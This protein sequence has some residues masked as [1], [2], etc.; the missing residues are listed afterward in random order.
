MPS[1]G[2]PRIHASFDPLFWVWLIYFLLLW[3]ILL[4]AQ[5]PG[6]MSDDSGEMAAAA[7][8]LGL[9]HPPGYPVLGLLGH[10]ICQIPLGTIAFRLNLS[11]EFLAL[12]S[13]LFILDTC[14]RL[15]SLKPK[16]PS[17]GTLLSREL[18]LA[19]MGIVFVSCRDVFAQGLTAKGCVY[20]LTLLFTSAAVW[21][22]VFQQNHP[23]DNRPLMGAWFLWAVGLANHWQTMILWV[24]FLLVW[25][26]QRGK[27]WKKRTT[28]LAA[29]LVVLGASF[30]IYLPLRA[31]LNCEPCWGYPINLP[32][33][34]W[35]VSRQ[36]VA[37]VEH[38]TQSTVFYHESVDE[39]AKALFLNW[40][41]GFAGLSLA[42]MILLW[43]QSRSLFYG[44]IA[45]F[46]P[47]FLGIFAIH[48]QYNTYLMPVYLVSLAGLGILFGFIA[49]RRILEMIDRPETAML[50]IVMLCLLSTWWLQHVF[51]LEDKSRY[52]LAEDFGTNV[53][54]GLPRGAILLADGDHYVMPI[55]YEHF[56]KGLRPDLVFE[57]SVFLYHGW[58][59]KQL[60]DQSEDLRPMV[61]SSDLFQD[62][63]NALTRAYARHPLFYSLGREFMQP[64]LEKM[65]G[66]WLPRGLAYAWESRRPTPSEVVSQASRIIASER[67]R[68]LEYFQA[69]GELDFSTQQIYR[70]YADQLTL[71]KQ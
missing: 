64:A 50:L 40:L 45:L 66:T 71:F 31:R 57:P 21:L 41:P 16:K 18:L 55:W 10:L 30:Y 36:L 11:S 63:L 8:G 38:W 2:K 34:Y 48:E 61:T 27:R 43:K 59:W 1:S 62:R 4:W 23:E 5:N 47:V 60:A 53:L 49:L 46:V 35:V 65:P 67:L 52:T 51:Q 70:F 39:M 14:R 25:S 69:A 3:Q 44:L 32:L 54:K 28:L 22:Y 68:G 42:G 17:G 33:F 37:G 7:F 12:F 6:L 15:K 26:L 29:T 13:L 20:T 19:T 24:P 56:A 9:P 58:G